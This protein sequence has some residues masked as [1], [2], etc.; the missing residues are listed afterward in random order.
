MRIIYYLT[1]LLLISSCCFEK[2]KSMK[3]ASFYFIDTQFTI[4]QNKTPNNRILIY[5]HIHIMK[6]WRLSERIF[7]NF[8]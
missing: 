8:I 5:I 4:K 6:E 1:C 2:N 3:L 7:L